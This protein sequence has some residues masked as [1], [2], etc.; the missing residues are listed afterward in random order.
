MRNRRK[1]LVPGDGANRP[2]GAQRGAG[3]SGQ[4]TGRVDAAAAAAA[5][6]AAGTVLLM[7]LLTTLLVP[8]LL[9]SANWC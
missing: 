6:A 9:P 1:G 8:L 2:S 4:P 5:A 3:T 7:L